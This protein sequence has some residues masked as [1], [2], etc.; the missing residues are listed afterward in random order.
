VDLNNNNYKTF[1]F[2]GITLHM[3]ALS[4]LDKQNSCIRHNSQIIDYNNIKTLKVAPKLK[5]W[6]KKHKATSSKD[7]K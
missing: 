6:Y 4:A 1:Y 5:S 3:T 2:K 7:E